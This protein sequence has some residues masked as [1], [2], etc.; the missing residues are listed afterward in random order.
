MKKKLKAFL[1]SH[2]KRKQ[3]KVAIGKD[4]L[5]VQRTI[6]HGLNRKLNI[7]SDIKS[8]YFDPGGLNNLGM[9]MHKLGPSEKPFAISKLQNSVVA[10]REYRFQ[11]W[12][13]NHMDN[14]LAARPYLLVPCNDS[15]SSVTSEFLYH[16]E[17]FSDIEVKS[18]FEQL[19]VSHVKLK[20]LSLDRRVESLIF[21]LEENT[22]I[23]S[24]LLNLVSQLD[25]KNAG[26]FVKKYLKER[27]ALLISCNG[28]YKKLENLVSLYFSKISQENISFMY[29]LV[30]GDFKQENIMTDEEGNLKL[31]DLQY[32][33]YGIRIWDL[34]FYY[35]KEKRFF[36]ELYPK[37]LKIFSWTKIE[38]ETFIFFYILAS[39]LHLK[40]KNLRKI[41]SF[42]LEPA[43]NCLSQCLIDE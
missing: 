4:I 35:S 5:S 11:R 19:N 22:K 32:F 15:Y 6:E 34:A 26:S 3:L 42:K 33:T 31:I 8:S 17:N 38:R 7:Q 12:Q 37:L 13:E 23:K 41:K 25:M 9:F 43:V 20:E 27:E 30:H 1:R 18:I 21:E 28:L 39:L 36:T 16:A 10:G 29:G 2:H 40:R 14:R 24:V